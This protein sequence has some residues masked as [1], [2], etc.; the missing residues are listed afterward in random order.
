MLINQPS[1]NVFGLSLN[2]GMGWAADQLG[3][4]Q[5]L[6]LSTQGGTRADD[7]TP[8]ALG[9]HTGHWE[10]GLLVAEAAR[11]L[12]ARGSSSVQRSCH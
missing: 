12:K 5:V 10:V 11:E 7:G 8:V 9:F 3:G 4:A 2:V 1:G 6:I